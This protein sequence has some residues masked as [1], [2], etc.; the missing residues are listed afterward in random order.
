[1]LTIYCSASSRAKGP[2]FDSLVSMGPK[3][4]PLVVHKLTAASDFFA[5]VL[6]NEVE[7]DKAYKVD[8]KD[9]LNSKV[10]QRQANLIVDMN[11]KR[12]F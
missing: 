6:Y 5:I 10:L 1:M 4:L 2:E 8:P 7:D 12:S 11:Y 9:I 3:I